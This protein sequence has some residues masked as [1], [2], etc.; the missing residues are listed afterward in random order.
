MCLSPNDFLFYKVQK[1]TLSMSSGVP[2]I[3]ICVNLKLTSEKM[4]EEFVKAQQS[5]SRFKI[6]L[7][8]LDS[9][10]MEVA[11]TRKGNK[12]SVLSEQVFSRIDLSELETVILSGEH[13][14]CNN[15]LF[16]QPSCLWLLLDRTSSISLLTKALTLSKRLRTLLISVSTA[17]CKPALEAVAQLARFN[18]NALGLFGG[19]NCVEHYHKLGECLQHLS[20]SMQ[21]LHLKSWRATCLPL[22]TLSA[23]SNLRV[24]SVISGLS[25]I[26]DS[27]TESSFSQFLKTLSSLEMLE[28]VEVE[29]GIGMSAGDLVQLHS[30]LDTSLPNLAHWHM[31][32]HALRLMKTDLDLPAN[33]SV[34]KLIHTFFTIQPNDSYN[35]TYRPGNFYMIC[36]KGPANTLMERWLVGLRPQVCFRLSA[37]VWFPPR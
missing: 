34:H 31:H 33:E 14:S 21:F 12:C 10:H 35:F 18:L 36:Q 37:E 22:N 2:P 28:Y 8:I 32:V 17:T 4:L 26:A 3:K 9:S 30:L 19:T 25:I 13:D 16:L 7:K 6:Q 15:E 29:Q 20:S 23:C 1:P 11:N 5:S 27:E 24:L